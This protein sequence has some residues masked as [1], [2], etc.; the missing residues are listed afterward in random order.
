MRSPADL[1][2]EIESRLKKYL[3]RDN[4]GIRHELL[5]TF[6]RMKSLT[7]AETFEHLRT[8]FTIS[9]HSVASMVGIIASKIGILRVKK[10]KDNDTTTYELKDQYTDLVVRLIGTV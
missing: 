7:I 3:S 10:D 6:V 8:K 1:K 4:S 2:T 5:N 9:Y